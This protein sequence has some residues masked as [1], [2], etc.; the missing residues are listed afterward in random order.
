RGPPPRRALVHGGRDGRGDARRLP[1]ADRG[2]RAGCGGRRVRSRDAVAM[3]TKWT[4]AV[5]G[6][7]LLVLAVVMALSDATAQRA[8]RASVG[9]KLVA[10]RTAASAEV[11]RAVEDTKAALAAWT[12]GTPPPAG[13]R[14]AEDSWGEDLLEERIAD[15]Y[16]AFN[17]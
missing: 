2:R 17:R 8:A 14:L 4:L 10:I 13:L 6:T 5:V 12:P 16:V 7:L 9:A 11:V 1:R 3:K 15:T